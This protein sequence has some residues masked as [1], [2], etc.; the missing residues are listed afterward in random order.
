MNPPPPRGEALLAQFPE[1]HELMGQ[2][3]ADQQ[4]DLVESFVVELDAGLSRTRQH[5]EQGDWREAG[6]DS[7]WVRG[8]LGSMGFRPIENEFRGFELLLHAGETEKAAATFTQLEESIILLCSSLRRFV[9][10][11]RNPGSEQ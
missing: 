9:E 7:H 6:R 5:L 1:F 4:N 10:R 2:L 11:N 3:D 8:S